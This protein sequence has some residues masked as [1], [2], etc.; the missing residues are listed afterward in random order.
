MDSYYERDCTVA[1]WCRSIVRVL[2]TESDVARFVAHIDE[3]GE[4]QE[5]IA[6]CCLEQ[7]I[8]GRAEYE[9]ITKWTPPLDRLAEISR[10]FPTL[11]LQ[12]EW[13]QPGDG[14][15]GC[16]VIMDGNRNVLE[17]DDLVRRARTRIREV[18][19]QHFHDG[20]DD[21]ADL[22]LSWELL[23][24]A[25]RLHCGVQRDE[26]D[27]ANESAVVTDV[28]QFARHAVREWIGATQED[29]VNWSQEGF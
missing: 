25:S 28:R 4:A 8:P 6:E 23:R 9:L 18:Y 22:E 21:G 19:P 13:D 17:L 5:D 11:T 1:N 7:R 26:Q 20:D 2:G 24:E 15:L 16:A 27:D 12:V 14:L 29:S 10:Q 3:E